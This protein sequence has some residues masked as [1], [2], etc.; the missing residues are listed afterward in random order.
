MTCEISVY[1][2]VLSKTKL[3]LK[4]GEYKFLTVSQNKDNNIVWKS[5]NKKI[6]KVNTKGKVLG[7][8]VGKATITATVDN[9]ILE[10]VVKVKEA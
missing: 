5:P 10:C 6:V 8:G 2:P 9:R 3:K 4:V 7:I 1:D